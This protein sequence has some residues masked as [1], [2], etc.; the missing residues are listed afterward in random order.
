MARTRKSQHRQE[1]PLVLIFSDGETEINYFRM[2]RS[3]PGR[4][5]NIRIETR[6]L[7]QK[8]AED[9]VKSAKR[10]ISSKCGHLR[11]GDHLYFVLDMDAA[12][13]EDISRTKRS[14]PEYMHLIISNPDIEYWFLLHYRYYDQK[15][16]NR[17]AISILN[18]YEP[19]YS[20]PDVDGI[21][22]SLKAGEET[23]IVN[24]RKVRDYQ[25]SNGRDPY[26]K[27]A[28]PCTNVD[29]LISQINSV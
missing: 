22:D 19:D 25:I 4:N 10:Y 21:Y 6:F 13:D 1:R 15:M 2:K 23:A 16:A 27:S 29:E 5:K 24:A 9:L 26:S 7:N 3:D 11:K 28:N 20:K 17:E 12:D 18:D 14:M 8:K